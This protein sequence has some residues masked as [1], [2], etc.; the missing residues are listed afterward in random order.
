M[1]DLQTLNLPLLPLTTGVVLPGMVVTIAV[2]SEEAAGA[3]AAARSADGRLILVPRREGGRYAAVGTIAAVENAGELPS[4]L[5]AVVIRGLHRATVG[6]GVPGTGNALWVQVEPVVDGDPTPRAQ[7]LAREYR[8]V[9]ENVLE[10][11]GTG[12]SAGALRGIGDPGAMA[13]TDG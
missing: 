8:A 5:R 13:D 4:G 9:I 11:R 1:D 6:T 3:L 10:Y 2:E 7:E 12:Q